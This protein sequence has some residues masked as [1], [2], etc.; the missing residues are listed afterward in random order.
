MQD[1]SGPK[2]E[3][4]RD[5]LGP[6]GHGRHVPTARALPKRAETMGTVL[7]STTPHTEHALYQLTR[8]SHG[9][10]HGVLHVRRFPLRIRDNEIDLRMLAGP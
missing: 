5:A 1:R 8:R 2:A 4:E 6:N 3:I 7:G 10:H 9:I